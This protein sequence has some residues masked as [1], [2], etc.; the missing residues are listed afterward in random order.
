MAEE[1]GKE[2]SP[3]APTRRPRPSSARSRGGA[4]GQ[5]EKGRGGPHFPALLRA[6]PPRAARPPRPRPWFPATERRP[7][8]Q[9][10]RRG[11]RAPRHRLRRGWRRWSAR[12]AGAQR[13]RPRHQARRAPGRV[14]DRRGGA[15]DCE[16]HDVE[17]GGPRGR[18]G[19]RGRAAL[20]TAATAPLP[21]RPP[22]AA[23]SFLPTPPHPLPRRPPPPLPP[24]SPAPV[25]AP[26][27]T[28]GGGAGTFGRRKQ[29]FKKRARCGPR[30][31]GGGRWACSRQPTTP[32]RT[33]SLCR[34]GEGGRRGR[35]RRRAGRREEEGDEIGERKREIER[36][37]RGC[38]ADKWAH[39]HAASTSANRPPKQPDGQM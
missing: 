24:S 22:P 37:E 4:V 35:P 16:G 39:C 27:A 21:W 11:Q 23:S 6:P 8:R 32:S 5:E 30:R 2:P 14:R 13:W 34:S 28:R 29:A 31:T 33:G 1:Q 19:E 12:G 38:N 9:G 18:A 15:R 20:G 25:A 3:A 17:E 26:A 7:G 36:R 10:Q